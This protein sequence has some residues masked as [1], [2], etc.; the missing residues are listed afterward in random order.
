M[1]LRKP[2]FMGSEGFSEEMASSDSLELGGLTMSG[3]IAM[4]TNPITGLEAADAS[5]EALSFGQ[6]G[7][8]LNGLDVQSAKITSVAAGDSAN[9]A[10]AYG[11][12]GAMLDGLDASS[13]K[14]TNVEDA[15]AAGDALVYAQSGATLSGLSLSV[16]GPHKLTGLA[17]GTSASDAVNKSQL[18]AAVAGLIPQGNVSVLK[19]ISDADQSGSDP[20]APSEGDAYVVNNWSTQTDGDIV[21]Y[22][23]SSWNVVVSNDAGDIPSGTRVLVVDSSA[24]GSFSTEENNIAEYDGSSWSFTSSSDGMYC[25]IV[26][27]NS[28]YENGGYIYDSSSTSWELFTGLGAV[29]AGDGLTKSGNEINVGAGNGITANAD[30]I[31]V[32]AGDGLTFGVVDLKI[33]LDSTAHGGNGSGLALGASGLSLEVDSGG[34]LEVDG[35]GELRVIDSSVY[36]DYGIEIDSGYVAVKTSASGGIKKTSQGVVVDLYANHGLTVDA[37]GLYLEEP[38]ST[39]GIEMDGNGQLAVKIDDTPDTLD[40]DSDG[41]KVVGLPSLF[42]VNGTAVGSDVTAPNLDTL[43]DGSNADALHTHTSGSAT[44]TPKISNTMTASGA[45]SKFDPVYISGV[46]TV[47]EAT[48]GTDSQARVI[49]VANESISDASSGRIIS[50]GI[51]ESDGS[52]T[53]GAPQYLASS[54]G[55]TESVP[56]AGNRIIMVGYALNTTD[57]FVE[58]HDYGKKAA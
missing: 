51:I 4:G 15:S 48:A 34:G 8:E 13:S 58:I 55:L 43:T 31:D 11:Q 39:G 19:M 36:G 17:D 57:L 41:L 47:S 16:L 21:E 9:D 33:D 7:A 45:I 40:S 25:F 27:E 54:G 1:A 6:S 50:S 2:L 23:G 37:N 49:G 44:E 10:L 53:T 12:S 56:G 42:K 38:L 18:D 14:I 32:N 26:G 3:A 30:S 24:A 20:G 29:T 5:G 46:D 22:D 35:D 28:V 52:F